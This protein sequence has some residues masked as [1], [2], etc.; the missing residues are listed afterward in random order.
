MEQQKINKKY[1]I[2]FESDICI[3]ENLNIYFLG[4]LSTITEEQLDNSDKN[5]KLITTKVNNSVTTYDNEQ[6]KY[7]KNYVYNNNYNCIDK[8]L[9]YNLKFYL[10]LP[11]IDLDLQIWCFLIPYQRI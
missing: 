11:S 7:K 8:I 2:S 5:D 6:L 10:N 1:T 9:F 4:K 3:F